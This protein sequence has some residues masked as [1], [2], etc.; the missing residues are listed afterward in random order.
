LVESEEELYEQPLNMDF[1]E[2]LLEPNTDSPAGFSEILRLLW[3][4]MTHGQ[5]YIYIQKVD[6]D[7]RGFIDLNSLANEYD[8]CKWLKSV[9]FDPDT[10]PISMDYIQDAL[11]DPLEEDHIDGKKY[12][13]LLHE[14][15][16]NHK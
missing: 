6:E 1:L 2:Q 10:M 12:M 8:V 3:C 5:K 13:E 9:G 11:E 7:W 15:L 16:F 14:A 4:C